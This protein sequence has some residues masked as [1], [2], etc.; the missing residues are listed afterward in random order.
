MTLRDELRKSLGLIPDAPV[1][2]PS[3]VGV[4]TLKES[5]DLWLQLY[6]AEPGQPVAEALKIIKAG[7]PE[8][9]R[10]LKHV[11]GLKP[12]ESKSIPPFD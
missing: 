3:S 11:G 12:G 4:A 10:Y 7:D 2:R 8:P 1:A 9:A 5:G 6:S